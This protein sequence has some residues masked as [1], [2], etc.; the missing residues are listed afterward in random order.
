MSIYELISRTLCKA[1][2]A[3]TRCPEC[4]GHPCAERMWK[5][6][7]GEAQAVVNALV[8]AG[9]MAPPATAKKTVLHR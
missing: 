3:G 2:C 7:S 5:T 6:F 1:A 9:Y 4:E 8:F